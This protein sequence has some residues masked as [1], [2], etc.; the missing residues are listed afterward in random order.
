MLGYSVRRQRA[1]QWTL[2]YK[3]NHKDR[4]ITHAYMQTET[5][6]YTPWKYVCT[7]CKIERYKQVKD[8]KQVSECQNDSQT[9]DTRIKR[10]ERDGTIDRRRKNVV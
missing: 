8:Y 7:E 3:Y 10:D 2:T 1:L 4:H 6:W 9:I 5:Q